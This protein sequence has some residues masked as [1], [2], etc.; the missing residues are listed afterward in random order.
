MHQP[1]LISQ[2]LNKRLEMNSKNA[3][4]DSTNN[5]NRD[6]SASTCTD[7]SLNSPSNKMVVGGFTRLN[8]SQQHQ[9][10]QFLTG[11]NEKVVPFSNGCYKKF[12]DSSNGFYHG[13]PVMM[14]MGGVDQSGHSD[15][16]SEVSVSAAESMMAHNRN[17][18]YLHGESDHE[19]E[20]QHAFH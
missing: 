14:M 3:C 19:R 20:D 15:S 8:P 18:L 11:T 5:S 6:E 17:R 10:F 1:A 4:S 12:G 2:A 9:P 7:L 16:N 13:G